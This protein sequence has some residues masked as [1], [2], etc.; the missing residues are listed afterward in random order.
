MGNLLFSPKG[1]LGPN[2]FLKGLLMIAVVYALLSIFPLINLQLGSLFTLLTVFLLFPLFC[3]LIKR[4]HDAGKSGWMSILFF[5]MIGIIG[6]IAQYIAQ[7]MFGGQALADMNAAT[8][9]IQASGASLGEMLQATVE[10]TETY[11]PDIVK[12]TT[13]PKAVFGF[14]GTMLAGYLTNLILGSDVNANQYG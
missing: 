11:G 9:E 10:L 3:I 12:N 5:M 8:Q 14:A 2:N 7:Q 6:L 1:R 4:C 13:L